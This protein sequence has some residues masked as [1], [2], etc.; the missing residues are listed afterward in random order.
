VLFTGLN[1]QIWTSSP[2]LDHVG[3]EGVVRI[4]QVE[5][6]RLESRPGNRAGAVVN[7][8]RQYRTSLAATRSQRRDAPGRRRIAKWPASATPRP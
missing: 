4:E 7:N 6:R 8:P 1:M 3:D 5:Q 2:R